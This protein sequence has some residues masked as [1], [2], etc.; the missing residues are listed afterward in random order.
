[1]VAQTVWQVNSALLKS[2]SCT[3]APISCEHVSCRK[4]CNG[5]YT[6][7]DLKK[8][9]ALMATKDGTSSI[10]GS[11]G[12]CTRVSIGSSSTSV[13]RWEIFLIMIPTQQQLMALALPYHQLLTLILDLQQPLPSGFLAF[14]PCQSGSPYIQRSDCWLVALRGVENTEYEK[15]FVKQ[16]NFDNQYACLSTTNKFL[17][18]ASFGHNGTSAQVSSQDLLAFSDQLADLWPHEVWSIPSMKRLL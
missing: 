10:V 15:A 6:S 9:E 17:Q 7:S 1:M 4:I 8:N 3:H 14:S 13:S 11:T 16:V 18:P 12:R 2:S 5:K